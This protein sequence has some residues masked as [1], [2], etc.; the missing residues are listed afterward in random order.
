MFVLLGNSRKGDQPVEVI[1]SFK[2]TTKECI[3]Q[4]VGF[5]LIGQL[6]VNYSLHVISMYTAPDKVY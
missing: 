3:Q 1:Y 6:L 2:V 4:I 5:C